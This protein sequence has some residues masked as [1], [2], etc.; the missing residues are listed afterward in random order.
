MDST[1]TLHQSILR[2]T[3]NTFQ[4][5]R[6]YAIP[7]EATVRTNL[8]VLARAT[9]GTSASWRVEACCKRVAGGGVSLIQGGASVVEARKD[10]GASGWNVQVN[11]NGNSLEVKVKGDSSLNVDWQ[12]TGPV[13]IFQPGG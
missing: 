4:S 12:V 7:D 3:N 2:T 6:S 11:A 9:D 10:G 13:L 5:L 1:E 8:T